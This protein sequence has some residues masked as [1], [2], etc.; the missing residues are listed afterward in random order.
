M[1]LVVCP[2]CSYCTYCFHG[3]LP[4]PEHCPLAPQK[5]IEFYPAIL[6]CH[7]CTNILKPE[8]LRAEG[9]LLLCVTD[10]MGESVWPPKPLVIDVS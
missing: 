3:F 9:R 2:E 10:V 8:P 6:H 1:T 7:L 4:V 5:I